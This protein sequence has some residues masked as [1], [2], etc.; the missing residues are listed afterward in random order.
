MLNGMLQSCQLSCWKLTHPKKPPIQRRKVGI[1][2][3]TD[4][5]TTIINLKLKICQI[6]GS[7]FIELNFFILLE[8]ICVDLLFVQTLLVAENKKQSH[9]T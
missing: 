7:M 9:M 5:D 8:K 3:L 4:V 2:Y 1:I 6:V